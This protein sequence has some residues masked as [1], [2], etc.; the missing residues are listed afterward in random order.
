MKKNEDDKLNQKIDNE[1]KKKELADKYGADF[2]SE[3]NLSPE[4]ENEWLN[5]IEEFEKQFQNTEQISVWEFIGKPS[6][7]MQ[8]ELNHDE[9]SSE[10]QRLFDIMNENNIYLD[11]LCEVDDKELHRFITEELFK[12]E[13]DN[14]RI[15][16]MMTNFIYEE[17]HPN[18]RYDI[19]MAYEYFFHSTLKKDK[20]VDGSG[21]D[22]LYVDTKNYRNKKNEH[23]DEEVVLKKVNDFLRSFDYFEIVSNE[24]QEIKINEEETDAHIDFKIH[25]NGRYH[26]NSESVVFHGNGFFKLNP[27]E[28]GGWDIYHIN[29]PGLAI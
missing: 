20:N 1:L 15:K 13:V 9:I 16:G 28:Y 21:Y 27:S 12:E 8:D 6:Y 7:K 2:G 22:L 25:F 18:A 3:S 23:I 24:I 4:L 19:E 10:L 26:N 14:V 17:F 5:Y 29:M 11:V